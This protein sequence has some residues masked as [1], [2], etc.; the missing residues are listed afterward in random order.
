[1]MPLTSTSSRPVPPITA[2]RRRHSSSVCASVK[3]AHARTQQHAAPQPHAAA[4]K[5][6]AYNR[7]RA[8]HAQRLPSR[9]GKQ[10]FH[11]ASAAHTAPRRDKTPASPPRVDCRRRRYA[12]HANDS[13]CRLPRDRQQ[14]SRYRRQTEYRE[15]HVLADAA[16]TPARNSENSA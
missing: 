13:R 2:Q 16:S 8:L 6:T 4:A 15:T 10:R 14:R 5:R 11:G 12:I 7:A 9:A 1:M 3:A